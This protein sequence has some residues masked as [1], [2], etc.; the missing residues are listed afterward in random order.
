LEDES[1]LDEDGG[2]VYILST[3]EL[4][5]L[6]KIGFTT[7][8]PEVRVKAINSATGVIIPWAVRYAWIRSIE[9]EG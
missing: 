8:S 5:E 2:F 4:P 7:K 3:R 6:L 9:V 1:A